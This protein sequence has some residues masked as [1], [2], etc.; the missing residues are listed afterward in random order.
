MKPY[1]L[2][3]NRETRENLE[4]TG[5]ISVPPEDGEPDWMDSVE[6]EEVTA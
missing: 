5:Q 4:L 6:V 3:T 2:W 1:W